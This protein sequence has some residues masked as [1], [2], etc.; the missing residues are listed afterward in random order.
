MMKSSLIGYTHSRPLLARPL[1]RRALRTNAH[2]RRR[3]SG[4]DLSPE[5][6]WSSNFR[7][8]ARRRCRSGLLGFS[9]RIGGVRACRIRSTSR[10][11][12]TNR[13]SRTRRPAVGL[14]RRSSPV[15]LDGFPLDGFAS[16]IFR[17][18]GFVPE[19]GDDAIPIL[20]QHSADDGQGEPGAGKDHDGLGADHGQSPF[21]QGSSGGMASH[22]AR[23]RV[24]ALPVDRV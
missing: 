1:D 7:K 19:R 8:R 22:S 5:L 2:S 24:K 13:R 6:A 21:H 11:C 12:L 14:A 18:E 20:R 4:R 3:A 16:A 9:S 23:L 15:P 17:L 10:E